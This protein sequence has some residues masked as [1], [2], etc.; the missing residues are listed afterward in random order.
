MRRPVRW[1][2][3]GCAAWVAWLLIGIAHAWLEQPL[4][5]GG[6]ALVAL[7]WGR[8][9]LVDLYAGFFVAAVWIV[10]TERTWKHA[11]FWLVVLACLGNV[12]TLAIF[13]LRGLRAE[14]VGEVL[15]PL[16][17]SQRA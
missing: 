17:H 3:W 10:A 8:V 13:T 9:T 15:L 5:E 11:L 2:A 7:P 1:I 4:G 6:S 16:R 12:A 14:D